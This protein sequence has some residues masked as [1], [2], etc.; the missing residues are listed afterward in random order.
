[1]MEDAGSEDPANVRHR[2]GVERFFRPA[3]HD[4][5]TS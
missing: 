4:H 1:M 5:G 2:V 3:I